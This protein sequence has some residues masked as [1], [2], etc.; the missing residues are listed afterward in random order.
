MAPKAW[1]STTH[2]S[3]V[4]R[5]GSPDEAESRDAL[6]TLC[7]AYWTPVFSYIRQRGQDPETARDLT[8]GFFVSILERGWIAHAKQERGRFRSF[9]QTSVKNFLSDEHDRQRALKR[10]GEQAPISIDA[11]D[12]ESVRAQEPATDVT[13]EAIFEQRW[14]M[15]LL[16]RATGDLAA[17]MERSGAGERFRLLRPYLISDADPPYRQLGAD[18]GMTEPAVRVALHR[19]RQRFGAKL[20]EHVAQT[21]DDPAK[22]EDELLY[23]IQ[24]VGA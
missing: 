8:Q 12:W 19:L 6:S 23:L 16:D 7:Q 10:G 20:R 17:D 13:P 2:W 15:A 21:V 18:L 4:L 3:V 11:D 9:L 24:A 22:T 5:A 14:A 1:F